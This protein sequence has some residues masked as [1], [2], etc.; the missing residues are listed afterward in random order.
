MNIYNLILWKGHWA[1]G[2]AAYG[3]LVVFFFAAAAVI[4]MA[5]VALWSRRASVWDRFESGGSRAPHRTR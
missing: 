1:A 2:L 4:G 3:D 5:R